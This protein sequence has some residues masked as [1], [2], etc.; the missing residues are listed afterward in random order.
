VYAE[1][2]I[3]S[4]GTWESMVSETAI[5]ISYDPDSTKIT[6]SKIFLAQICKDTDQNGAVVS[7]DDWQG[8]LFSQM[9]DDMTSGGSYIDHDFCEKDPYY[10][11][12][13]LKDMTRQGSSD[14]TSTTPTSLYDSPEYIDNDFPNSVTSITSTFEV[15]PVC[16]D[17]GQ[18]L[19]SVTWTYSRTKNSPGHGTTTDITDSTVSQEFRDALSKFQTNHANGTMCP[20]KEL[21]SSIPTLSEWKQIFL[22]LF[23]I[24][25]GVA[26]IRYRQ[27]A[28]T[29]CVEGLNIK[30]I[31]WGSALFEGVVLKNVLT[32]CLIAIIISTI[33]IL[34]IYRELTFLDAVGIIVCSPLLAYILNVIYIESQQSKH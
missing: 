4:H 18:I 12:E 9:T 11:G 8:K 20:E 5:I 25:S 28:L 1:T 13:D 22:T 26:F 27:Y 17:N 30:N 3:D 14:G 33:L 23:I 15:C 34:F 16:V 32:W 21:H 7:P 24:A 2:I 29:Y 10:N 6:C 31:S 19:D